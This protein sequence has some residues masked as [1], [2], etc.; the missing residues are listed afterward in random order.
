MIPN[1]YQNQV[2]VIVLINPIAIVI[3]EEAIHSVP[4]MLCLH[5]NLKENNL[6]E[7]LIMQKVRKFLNK[8]V[9]KNFASNITNNKF[10]QKISRYI[11]QMVRALIF[12]Y[13][14]YI[15]NKRK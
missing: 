10:T 9:N 14:F 5:P 4:I 8:V 12:L 15:L 11:I 7:D 1:I 13:T 6:D 3:P 2:C